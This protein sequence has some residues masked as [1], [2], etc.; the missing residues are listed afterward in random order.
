MASTLPDASMSAHAALPAESKHA[1][2]GFAKWRLFGASGVLLSAVALA[3]NGTMMQQENDDVV[4]PPGLKRGRDDKIRV[5]ASAA[6]SVTAS[7]AVLFEMASY[8]LNDKTDDLAAE[9]RKALQL[10]VAWA[11]AQFGPRY[12]RAPKTSPLADL[13]A[14]VQCQ[15]LLIDVFGEESDAAAVQPLGLQLVNQ[16]NPLLD[17]C[18]E[19]T[20]E[21][22]GLRRA[23]E[24]EG[25]GMSVGRALAALH[26]LSD[27]EQRFKDVLQGLESAHLLLSRPIVV[28]GEVPSA[29]QN[30]S[31]AKRS[32]AGLL[33]DRLWSMRTDLR[34][35]LLRVV[36]EARAVVAKLPGMSLQVRRAAK[37]NPDLLAGIEGISLTA[38]ENETDAAF[39][40]AMGM[41][42]SELALIASLSG[43]SSTTTP[44]FGSAPA[45]PSPAWATDAFGLEVPAPVV[46]AEDILLRA[47]RASSGDSASE[48]AILRGKR[49]LRHAQGILEPLSLYEAVSIRLRTAA[50]IFVAN[51]QP[52]S[53]AQAYRDLAELLLSRG[54]HEDALEAA[55]QALSQDNR[56]AVA[57]Y[58]QATLRRSL[59]ELKTD[60]DVRHAKQQLQQAA[61]RLPEEYEAHRVTSHAELWGWGIVAGRG[62]YRTCFELHDSA[63]V[64]I[65]LFC[66]LIMNE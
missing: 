51:S 11:P 27:L 60:E 26:A 15:G 49:L 16:A 40:F 61:G 33:V 52:K 47:E 66:R 59:G 7:P 62:N 36:R 23:S 24:S 46:A 29:E 38:I 32:D 28:H 22:Q 8:R 41:H 65:C 21:L 10:C 4:C 37:C 57:L 45:A 48:R 39:I 31:D 64:L 18:V 17:R 34:G 56:D 19:L 53:A 2:G 58:L 14:Q 25:S 30:V 12:R 43:Q 44:L 54:Y 9:A 50:D 35:S 6:I 5:D 55:G 13:R 42:Q 1:D 20:N 3:L 63:R